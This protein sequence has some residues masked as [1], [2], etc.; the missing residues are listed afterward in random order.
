MA[1]TELK[2]KNAKPSEKIQKL[3]DSDGLVLLIKPSGAKYWRLNY[4]FNGKQK[5]LALGKYPYVSLSE[6]R[7][8]RLKYKK[9]IYS[10]IDPNELKTEKQR[11]QEVDAQ[12]LFATIAKDWWNANY[13]D[14]RATSQAYLA[15]I[16]RRCFTS[17]R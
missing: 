7:E 17:T 4:R 14:G 11:Q 10:G 1:L 9:M 2:A 5:T 8:L 3:T 13:R 15:F 12:A 6:A 16:R